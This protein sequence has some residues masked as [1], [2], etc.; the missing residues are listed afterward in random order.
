MGCGACAQGASARGCREWRVAYATISWAVWCS[1]SRRSAQT[2]AVQRRPSRTTLRSSSRSRRRTPPRACSSW[3]TSCSSGAARYVAPASHNPSLTACSCIDLYHTSSQ[4]S[5]RNWRRR[6][7]HRSSTVYRTKGQQNSGAQRPRLSRLQAQ[8]RPP[9]SNRS[10]R[11]RSS[12]TS[13]RRRPTRP[14]SGPGY[15]RC[16]SCR[17]R[18][19][20]TRR[21]SGACSNP[22]RR[23]R[24]SAE[25]SHSSAR[26]SWVRCASPRLLGRG[27]TL[28]HRRAA[29]PPSRRA[30]DARPHAARQHV[31]RGVLRA[32][33]AGARAGEDATRAGGAVRGERPAGE[34]RERRGRRRGGEAHAHAGVARGVYER[35]VSDVGRQTDSSVC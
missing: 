29:R 9:S 1:C 32:R 17:R 8:P 21:P 14:A 11:P 10:P 31:R 13:P 30:H 7:S 4:S 22:R 20:T 5:T 12:R 25:C 3:S 24:R 2:S 35:R 26:S 23:T 18:A 34:Q 15:A 19:C 6:T 27:M 33:R 16:C 28:T